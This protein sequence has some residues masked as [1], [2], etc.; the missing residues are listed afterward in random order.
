MTVFALRRRAWLAGLAALVIAASPATLVAQDVEP[1]AAI[2]PSAELVDRIVAVVGDTVVL[3]TEVLESLLQLQSQGATLPEEGTPA[4]DSLAFQ[5]LHDLVDQLVLLQQAK[6]EELDVSDDVLDAE[7]DRRFREVR[8]AFPTATE[9]E[10][11]ISESGR[12]LVQY[13]QFLRSQVRAQM[14]IE[15][16]IQ[17]S[18]SNLPP[19]VV[20]DEEVQAWFDGNL[21]GQTQPATIT[22][23]QLVLEPKPSED[24]EKA[25]FERATQILTEI[26][27]GKDFEVAA[28]EYSE[29]PATRASGGDLGWVRRAS[30]DADFSRAAWSAR[31]GTPIGPV[32][33]QF[34]NHLIKVEN[35]RG[36]ERKIRHILLRHEITEDDFQRA[37]SLAAQLADSIRG[38]ASFASIAKEYGSKLEP[39]RVPQ[40]PVD[41]I[42]QQFPEY[43]EALVDPVPGRVVGPFVNTTP[44]GQRFVI[45]RVTEYIQQGPYQFADVREEIRERLVLDKGYAQ[46]VED[47]R[48]QAHIDIKI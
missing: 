17:Q 29:D 13:R 34:G 20:S 31:T 1:E 14:L 42:A 36:G 3:Y 32:R 25:A 4:F 7:T 24:A 5:T 35:T 27:D 9:F 2:D 40:M 12:N 11:A 44:R 19:V 21:T 16:F 38:G 47:L 18:R 45:V 30:L 23:E 48:K 46:F 37:Q 28:R 41:R 22:F 15:Q 43:A 10:T 39:L 8:N 26:R 33:T 6:T